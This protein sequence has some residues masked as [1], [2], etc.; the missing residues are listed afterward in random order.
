MTSTQEAIPSQSKNETCS[1]NI[2]TK[3]DF[4]N[5]FFE[6]ELFKITLTDPNEHPNESLPI[7][8]TQGPA[9][10]NPEAPTTSGIAHDSGTV[11]YV[12]KKLLASLS[13]DLAKH[14]ENRGE[15]SLGRVDTSTMQWFLQWAYHGECKLYVLPTYFLLGPLSSIHRLIKWMVCMYSTA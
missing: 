8:T 7:A 2:A 4:D 12:H 6:S 3:V 5:L 9:K 11:F 10:Y 14:T 15:M 1:G 13:P